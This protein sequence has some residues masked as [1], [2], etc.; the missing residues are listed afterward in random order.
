VRFADLMEAEGR[1]L[2]DVVRVEGLTLR[3]VLSRLGIGLA[4]LLG[5]APLAIA[6]LGL[7]LAALYMG[8]RG[9]IGPAGAA[10]LTGVVT[11]AV[12]GG[13]LWVYRKLTL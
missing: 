2:R 5:A 8:L 11:L 7:L 6:G 3:R 9:P 10:A 13:M 12:A 4:V 1:S